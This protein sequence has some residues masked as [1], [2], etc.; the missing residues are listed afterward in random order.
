MVPY[1]SNRKLKKQYFYKRPEHPE[2]DWNFCEPKKTEDIPRHFY[3]PHSSSYMACF[4]VREKLKVLEENFSAIQSLIFFILFVSFSSPCL[5]FCPL[6][7]FPLETIFFLFPQTEHHLAVIREVLRRDIFFFHLV[8][9]CGEKS[10]L[11]GCFPLIFIL[12]FI[13]FK[14]SVSLLLLLR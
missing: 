8:T 11:V 10:I 13:F 14:R 1:T 2:R 3:F 5:L 4:F 6:V 7:R 9:L 12:F